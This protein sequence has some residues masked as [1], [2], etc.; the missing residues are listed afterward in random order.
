MAHEHLMQ[1]IHNPERLCEMIMNRDVHPQN[2]LEAIE[3]G[4]AFQ[5][6]VF[7]PDYD[8]YDVTK[9]LLVVKQFVNDFLSK[10]HRKRLRDDHD[11]FFIPCKKKCI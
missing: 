3:N 5:K 10:M 11:D 7:G 9:N 8:L 1:K 4:I 2:M 6:C